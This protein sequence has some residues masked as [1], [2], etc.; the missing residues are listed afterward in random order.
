M[1][2]IAI[3]IPTYNRAKMLK[4]TCL[5][6]QSIARKDIFDIYIY[7]SSEGKDSKEELKEILH[8]ENFFY[9]K[10]SETTHSSRKLYDIFQNEKMQNQ[11][12]YLWILPDYLFFSEHIINTII[13][14]LK[15]N[16]DMLMLDI[17]DPEK[18]GDKQYFDPNR[19]FSEYAWSM[20]QF[21]SMILNCL[22]VLKTANWGYL[23]DKY[24]NEE[25][26]NFSHVALYFERMLQ[27]PDLQ[28]FHLSVERE[29]IFVS[30]YRKSQ[31]EYFNDYLKIWGYRWYETI[32]KLPENY[33]NKDEAIKKICIYTGNLGNENVAELILRGILNRKS[34]KDYKDRWHVIS[35]VPSY[36]VWII[37]R[38]PRFFV[39]LVAEHGSVKRGIEKII[40]MNCIRKFSGRYKKIYLYGA[41]TIAERTADFLDKNGILFEAFV[42]TALKENKKTLKGH[43]VIEISQIN[44]SSDCGIILALNKAN[45]KQVIPVLRRKGYKNLF[46]AKLVY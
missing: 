37:M 7:D 46:K 41:G 5:Q 17:F 16:W 18:K 43:D 36:K 45:R 4:E 29:E 38:M 10:L 9:K 11:Y 33:T 24:L 2:E 32:H 1:K 30:K 3:C 14:K 20:T 21:G 8:N 25:S 40:L 39:D 15:E 19:I 42:V 44:A 34:F 13:K 23:E 31:S 27:I 6:I 22:T 28:F 35:T 26:C 12:E